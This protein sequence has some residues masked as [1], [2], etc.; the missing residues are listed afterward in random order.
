MV[1]SRINTKCSA[2]TRAGISIPDS[3]KI[4]IGIVPPSQGRVY[5]WNACRQRKTDCSALTRAGISCDCWGAT[6][7]M[8]FRPHKGGYI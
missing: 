8:G 6:E 3:G 7:M 2:L 1:E 4:E 5:H